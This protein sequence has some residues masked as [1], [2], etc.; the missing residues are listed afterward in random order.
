M[1]KI[2]WNDPSFWCEFG[3]PENNQKSLIT[4]INLKGYIFSLL[5]TFKLNV[6]TATAGNPVIFLPWSLP[7]K[8]AHGIIFMI[9][10]YN[11]MDLL[12]LN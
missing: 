4:L 3:S 6:G 5:L 12:F 7:T 8:V 1:H 10:T 9:S 11:K 2:L